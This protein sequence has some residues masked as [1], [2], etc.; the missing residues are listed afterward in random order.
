MSVRIAYPDAGR[1]NQAYMVQ[2]PLPD[3]L[4]LDLALAPVADDD[5]FVARCAEA[6][7]VLLGWYRMT[8]TV[9]AR[10]PRLR[11]VSFLGIGASDYVDIPAARERGITVCNTPGYGDG[12]VAEH[13]LALMLA[14]ARHVPHF[15]A[16]T[17]RGEWAR[18]PGGVE[19]S[20]RTLA[21]VGF[22]GI[23]Q[24]L[25]RLVAGFG[26][27]V[28]AWTRDPSRHQAQAAELGVGFMELDQVLAI[29]DLVSVHV[30]LTPQ[31]TG[32]LDARRLGLLKPDAI[33]VNTA[34]GPVIDNTALAALLA[35]RRL[36]GAGLDVFDEEPP[37]GSP[38]LGLANVV[39]TPHVAFNTRAARNALMRI[40]VQN[41]VG[42]AAGSPVNVL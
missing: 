9:L 15:H 33:L 17:A 22:G 38:L 8:D 39:L 26:M 27:R 32:L 2:N 3:G 34:R 7:G 35:E 37:E 21:L 42:F 20:G 18:G 6:D 14:V 4:T 11:C 30:A 23:A 25:A 16:L 19:L 40:A 31:T 29:A 5:E 12:A 10:L 13:A 28:V 24:A 36:Y 41:L 1:E